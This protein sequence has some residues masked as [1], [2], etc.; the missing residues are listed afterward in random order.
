MLGSFYVL[1]IYQ[2]DIRRQD[3]NDY[4]YRTIRAC[5]AKYCLY[6]PHRSYAD[7]FTLSPRMDYLFKGKYLFYRLEYAYNAGKLHLAPKTQTVVGLTQID[8]QNAGI[9]ESYDS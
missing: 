1:T 2:P 6:R 4:R 3:E 7:S 5:N 8:R 9:K